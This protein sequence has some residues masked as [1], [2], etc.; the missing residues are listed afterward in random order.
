MSIDT[1]CV[2]VWAGVSLTFVNADKRRLLNLCREEVFGGGACFSPTDKAKYELLLVEDRKNK[3]E[4]IE[5]K[6]TIEKLNE[7]AKES[8]LTINQLSDEVRQSKQRELELQRK[9]DEYRSGGQLSELNVNAKIAELQA[10]LSVA[11]ETMRKEAEEREKLAKLCEEQGEQLR[12]RDANV[13]AISGDLHK[14]NEIIKK[15]QAEIQ[16]SHAKLDVLSKVTNKQDE[17][18]NKKENHVKQLESDLKLCLERMKKK[19]RNQEQLKQ[20]LVALREKFEDSKKLISANEKV[21]SWLNKQ[22]AS[23][24]VKDGE[25]TAAVAAAGGPRVIKGNQAAASTH[26]RHHQPFPVHLPKVSVVDKQPIVVDNDKQAYQRDALAVWTSN[27]DP[28]K[29]TKVT[30]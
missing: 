22:L 2:I 18:V 29:C 9:L 13:E 27:L 12:E 23:L 30:K 20:Q 24:Q 1:A 10:Q 14:A 3:D 25:P 16:K 19:E 15:L 8:Q 17:V 26:R 28:F 21:I 7:K 6:L 5:L 11:N 4:I